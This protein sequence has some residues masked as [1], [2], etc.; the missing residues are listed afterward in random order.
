MC[1]IAFVNALNYY[2]SHAILFVW[3]ENGIRSKEGTTQ[4]D[5]PSMAFYAIGSL[6]LI[7]SL[8][9]CENSADQVAF[10]DDLTGGGKLKNLRRLFDHIV[11]KGP[12]FGY[13]AEPS[14]SWLIV[15][16][17]NFDEAKSIFDGAGVNITETCTEE[18]P[19]CCCWSN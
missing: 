5:P 16:K 12:L 2:Y 9:E 10:A 1:P 4:G 7:W 19:R 13:N 14:K 6:P 18:A 3:V 17:R 11:D 15:K 8:A